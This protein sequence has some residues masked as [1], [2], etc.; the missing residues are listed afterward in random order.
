MRRVCKVLDAA[1]ESDSV[2]L[3]RL[4]AQAG[5]WGDIAPGASVSGYPARDHREALRAQ[6]ALNRLVRLA[7][8]LEALVQRSHASEPA[9]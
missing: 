1:S 7:D 5:V 4:A 9:R 8:Q 3:A 6:A 2:K